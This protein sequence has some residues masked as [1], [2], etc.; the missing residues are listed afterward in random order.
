MKVLELTLK[1]K[2]FNMI[3]SG[4]KKEEYRECKDYWAWRL[5]SIKGKLYQYDAIKFTNG[6]GAHRPWILV[7]CKGL[8]IKQGNPEWGAVDGVSYFTFRLGRILDSDLK[9]M[10]K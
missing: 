7:E 5:M 9:G 8:S 6:Y 3:L 1:K 2:W 10:Y 4:E